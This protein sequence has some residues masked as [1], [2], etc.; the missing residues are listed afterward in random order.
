M[1]AWVCMNNITF[2]SIVDLVGKYQK[3][4][5]KD[6]LCQRLYLLNVESVNQRYTLRDSKRED[7]RKEYKRYIEHLADIRYE[8]HKELH[9]CQR[10]RAA[11]CWQYQSCE[12]D[13]NEDPLFKAVA[14]VIEL[15][16]LDAA[17]EIKGEKVF[18]NDV[19][20]NILEDYAKKNNIDLSD[21]WN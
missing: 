15:A 11:R 10:I 8:E 6:L 4:N 19:A 20:Y 18:D 1:S 5:N 2:S 7:D 21:M 17:S 3:I 13:C 12:G 14:K 9:D 16:E